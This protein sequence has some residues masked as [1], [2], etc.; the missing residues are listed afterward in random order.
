MM[1]GE[2]RWGGRGAKIRPQT[3]PDNIIYL[4][5]DNRNTYRSCWATMALGGWGEVDLP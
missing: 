5:K 4:Y 3:L 2:G 1:E